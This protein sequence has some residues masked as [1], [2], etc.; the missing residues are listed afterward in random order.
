MAAPAEAAAPAT[1]ARI[2]VLTTGGTIAGV[3]DPG[4]ASAYHSGLAS[5]DSLLA[6]SGSSQLARL[7]VQQ[8]A[9]IGSQ[10]MNDALWLE[11]ARRITSL[12]AR[13]EADGVVVTH[14]TDT[15]EE[16]AFF[17]DLVLPRGRSVVLT[18]AMRPSTAISADG[19]SNL[20]QAI[21]VAASPSAA[22]RGVL[23]ILDDTI[24]G[25]RGVQK[26]HTSH[27]GGFGSPNSGPLGQIDAT[28]VRFLWPVRDASGAPRF[29]L[30]G[31]APLPRV[32]VVYAHSQMDT[33]AIDDA[34][35]RGARGLVLAGV[36]AGNMSAAAIAAFRRH[37]RDGIVVVRASRTGAGW[38]HR[39]VEVDD[40]ACGFVAA[41]DLSVAKAR[42]LTQLL[43]A[44]AVTDP[45]AVQRAFALGSQT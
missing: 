4:S 18:G 24:H 25:A 12:F 43:I 3:N 34:V 13:N 26:T 36:G 7:T 5:G 1:S 15:M 28:D 41:L 27:V 42:V 10:D 32:E 11:L 2:T 16:T 22:H 21:R 23:A 38:V 44:A 8:V 14:G 29:K 37:A 31:T 40:D 6:A 9:A 19:P 20:R 30:P 17:L 33:G 35:R 45:V 39:N